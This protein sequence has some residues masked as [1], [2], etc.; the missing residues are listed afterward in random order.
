MEIITLEFRKA[1]IEELDAVF[2]VFRDAIA[3]M[4]RN[5]IPQW[6]ERYPDR[7]ILTEDI[8][9]NEL[10]V[11]TI[12]GEIASVFVLNSEC[13]EEYENGEWQYSDDSFCVIHRLCVN[14]KFQNRGIGLETMRHIEAELKK[15]GAESVRFDAFTL[16]P[17]ALRLYDKLGYKKVGYVHF[18]KGRFVLMEKKL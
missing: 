15:E 14:P 4:D 13:D 1:T 18:R 2:Q 6:D 17:Y 16:N 7:E 8:S 10:F 3:E 11:G 5:G 9:K 12:G